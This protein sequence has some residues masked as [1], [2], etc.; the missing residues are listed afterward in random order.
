LALLSQID[1]VI[2]LDDDL[3]TE[4]V[5]AVDELGEHI[6]TLLYLNLQ[7]PPPIV[8]VVVLVDRISSDETGW[9]QFDNI[10]LP[11]IS[12]DIAVMLQCK[13]PCVTVL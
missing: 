8:Y 13:T 3:L 7:N 12:L 2:I 9:A 6:A 4:G 1:S 11:P 10:L 5:D